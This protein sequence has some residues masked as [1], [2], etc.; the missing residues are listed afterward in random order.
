M[1]GEKVMSVS[2]IYRFAYQ[3]RPDKFD[4]TSKE[5][6]QQV[7][8]AYQYVHSELGRIKQ[9][10]DSINS[11]MV[12]ISIPLRYQMVLD[13]DEVGDIRYLD[14]LLSKSCDEMGLE[15]ISL[16]D[17]LRVASQIE[18]CYFPMDGHLN[19]IGNKVVGYF[20][21]NWL[22]TKEWFNSEN[23]KSRVL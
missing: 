5:N 1:A 22:M 9:L 21:G 17:T 19:S 11:R 4:F 23:N 8:D 2:G 18:E 16:L 12:V 13:L 7:S 6:Q 14:N 20:L 3:N 15:F 10:A